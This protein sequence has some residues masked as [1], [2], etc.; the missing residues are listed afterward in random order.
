MFTP[1]TKKHNEI[2]FSFK[3]STKNFYVQRNRPKFQK[4]L[5]LFPDFFAKIPKVF[6]FSENPKPSEA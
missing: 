4:F 6:P 2:H 5:F 1:E 3:Y